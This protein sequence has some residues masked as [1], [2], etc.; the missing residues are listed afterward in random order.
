MAV[1]LG[2]SGLTL[3]NFEIP[4]NTP[5]TVLQI[6]HVDWGSQSYSTNS[7][8]NVDYTN[9]SGQITPKRS[10][11]KILVILS[12]GAN[13]ICDGRTYLKRNGTIVKDEWV[14]TDRSDDVYDYN[15][16]NAVYLD[17]P[18]TTSTVTYQIGGRATGCQNVIRF[19]RTDNSS[20]L[21]LM[22]LSQ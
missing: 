11:S 20:S 8:A 13:Y 14:G 4:H 2:P 6:V 16:M 1:S 12:A 21:T 10:D 3:D 17:S 5:S 7:S 15:Q 22:E 9:F 18:A 19:G